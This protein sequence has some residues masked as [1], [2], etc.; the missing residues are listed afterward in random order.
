MSKKL[1]VIYGAAISLLVSIHFLLFSQRQNLQ[2]LIQ[3]HHLQ[4]S[5]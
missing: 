4:P 5:P 1:A 3:N 2:E